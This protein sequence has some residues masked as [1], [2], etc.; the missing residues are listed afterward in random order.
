MQYIHGKGW[1]DTAGRKV[2][3]MRKIHLHL[4]RIHGATGDDAAFTRLVIESRV[5]R[6][7]LN[8]AWQTGFKQ[9]KSAL[10]VVR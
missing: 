8:E 5:S 10:E 2:G 6:A 4:A 3:S 9:R 1:F 7:A